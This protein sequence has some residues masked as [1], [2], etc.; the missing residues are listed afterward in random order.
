M[1]TELTVVQPSIKSVGLT[2]KENIILSSTDA[3]SVL[4]PDIL[5]SVNVTISEIMMAIQIKSDNRRSSS[6]NLRQSNK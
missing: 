1:G 3:T 4:I 6:V 2:P 5:G